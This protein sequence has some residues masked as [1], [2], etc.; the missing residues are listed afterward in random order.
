MVQNNEKI[1]SSVDYSKD[2]RAQAKAKGK[3]KPPK[4]V[5]FAANVIPLR[6]DSHEP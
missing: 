2:F 6:N 5:I 1:M 4:Y 3:G